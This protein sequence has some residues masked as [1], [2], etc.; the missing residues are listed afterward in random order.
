MASPS[1]SPTLC[2]GIPTYNRPEALCRRINEV[3]KYHAVIQELLICDNS[4][5][6]SQLVMDAIHGVD[7]KCTYI[8]NPVNIG[9]GANFLRVLENV[10]T[11][12]VWWRGD[13]DV[14]SAGQVDAVTSNLSATPRLILISNGNKEVFRGK[15][16]DSFVDNFEKVEV[17]L[18]ASTVVVPV[19]IAKKVLSLGYTNIDWPHVAIILGM[20]RICPDLEFVVIPFILNE[21]EFRDIGREGL[22]WAL[23]NTTIKEFPR[24]AAML[25]SESLKKRYI[26]N[27]RRTKRFSLVRTMAGM[28]LGFTT[29]ERL[30]FKTFQNLLSPSNPKA[31]LL[32]VVLYLMTL[33]PKL[34]YQIVFAI[35]WTRLSNEERLDLHLDFIMHH[36]KFSDVF[37]ALREFE[38]GELV[39]VSV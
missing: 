36:A 20:F 33:V 9:A 3:N 19:E 13:D 18:W 22:G 31:T 28:R 11:D 38:T 14:I 30:T 35:Y 8:K 39:R 17:M 7:V 26:R 4:K 29:Q 1:T 21:N 34:L 5:E 24:T 6:T 2:V 25:E 37:K 16:I 15:G 32:G 10:S 12:Y 27:W 23:F